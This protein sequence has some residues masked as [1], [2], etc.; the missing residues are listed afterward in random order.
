MKNNYFISEVVVAI[1]MLVLVVALFNPFNIWMN[2]MVTMSVILALVATFAIFAIF[3]WKEKIR[4]EREE[5]HRFY[6][7]RLAFLS[8][9]TVLVAGVVVQGLNH[10]IDIWLVLA[11]EVMV[12]A[13]I[14]GRIYT[15]VK[16]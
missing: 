14:I 16:Q 6:A 7:S 5:L 10:S 8:G 11:L 4:D 3:I 1:I 15:R 2:S 12:F 13:K 9:T